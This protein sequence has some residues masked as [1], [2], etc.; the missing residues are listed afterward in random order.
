MKVFLTGG[1]GNVGAAA[2]SR[3]VERG[4][5]VTVVG[6]RAQMDVPGATYRQCDVGTYE[7]VVRE[8]NGHDSVVHLAAIPNP[9]GNPGR[10]VFHSN[11][12][13]TFHVF[14]AAAEHGI[15]RVVVASS[16][17]ALGYFFGDR[18]FPLPYLP[19]DEHTPAL[20]TDA[21]SF[22]KQVVEDIARYFWERDRISSVCLRLP[23]VFSHER[24]LERQ[25]EGAHPSELM[26][27]LLALPDAE[28]LARL[29]RM[30]GAYDRYRRANRWD[31]R[32]RSDSMPP[33]P[34][35][36][37]EDELRL[38]H[39]KANLFAYLDERDSAQSIELAATADYEGSHPLFVNARR[40]SAGLPVAELA[41]LFWPPVPEIRPQHEGDDCAVSIDRARELLGFDPRWHF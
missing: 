35:D 39:W 33:L 37:S 25:S 31:T 1:T 14:E 40:N 38:M 20:T 8:M 21:Y 6:R 2:V 15:S 19:V 4:H 32:E 5:E 9:I 16:I 26:T 27:E 24:V 18:G 30:H 10:A 12:Q 23:G 7:C 29:E 13:G 22:S 34:H 3:L 11:A 17:N 36:L 41:K 28:R